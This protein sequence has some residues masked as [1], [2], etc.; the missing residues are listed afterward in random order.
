[1]SPAPAAHLNSKLP[2]QLLHVDNS[3]VLSTKKYNHN[4]K[5]D[6]F[7]LVG[8]LRTPSL[9]DHFSSH[10]KTTLKRQ[11]RES[12]YIQVCNIG[13]RQSEHQRLL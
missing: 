8:M 2:S 5:V 12:G 13:S 4:L 7:Y 3:S 1:M 11:E 10:E 6:L 9:G